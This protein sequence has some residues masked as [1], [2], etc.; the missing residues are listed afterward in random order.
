MRNQFELSK[1]KLNHLSLED[2]IYCASQM[3]KNW[4]GTPNLENESEFS[5]DFLKNL[6]DLK[7]LIEKDFIE[8]HKK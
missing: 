6:K 3:I 7:I 4:S 8:D 1:K 2:F 5:R